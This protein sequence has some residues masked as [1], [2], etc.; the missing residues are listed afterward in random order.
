M[1]KVCEVMLKGMQPKHYLTFIL[2]PWRDTCDEFHTRFLKNVC[3]IFRM[4]PSMG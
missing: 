4:Y 3:Q 1:S 2:T